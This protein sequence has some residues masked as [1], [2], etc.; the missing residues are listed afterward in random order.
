MH[1][2]SLTHA[3]NRDILLGV[4]CGY[5]GNKHSRIWH[6]IGWIIQEVKD[7]RAGQSGSVALVVG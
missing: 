5:T 3:D 6:A 4:A 7:K 1:L 2:A